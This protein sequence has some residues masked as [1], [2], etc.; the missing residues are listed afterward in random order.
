[1]RLYY[2]QFSFLIVCIMLLSMTLV[3]PLN[4]AAISSA[5]VFTATPGNGMVYLKWSMELGPTDAG[6]MILK[7]TE[8]YNTKAYESGQF[9]MLDFTVGQK[10][11]T[12]NDVENGTKYY[13]YLMLVNERLEVRE[14]TRIEAVATPTGS[15]MLRAAS[16]PPVITQPII[17]T[18]GKWPNVAATPTSAVTTE[19]AVV[20]FPTS[21]LILELDGQ[22]AGSV[23]SFKGG[24]PYAEVK[25]ITSGTIHD[26]QPSRVKYADIELVVDVNMSKA[27]LKWL[28][29]SFNDSGV[30]KNGSIIKIGS[31]GPM[32]EFEVYRLNFSNAF[33]SEVT[34]P[35]IRQYERGVI[36][37]VITPETT[38]RDTSRTNT[39]LQELRTMNDA[40]Y[41]NMMSWHTNRFDAT[42]IGIDSVDSSMIKYVSG[43]K[44]KRNYTENEQGN[45]ELGTVEV[46]NLM[47]KLKDSLAL[48]FYSWFNSSV[49]TGTAD[50]ITE[51]NAVIAYKA[52]K[53]RAY[54]PIT[55]SMEGVGILKVEQLPDGT[56]LGEH[57]HV[58]VD[59][60]VEDCIFTFD[61]NI[62]F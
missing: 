29:N 54:F 31:N 12:D 55:F 14:E 43:L 4:A 18:D 62:G 40:K 20:D 35:D 56:E 1:M 44:L 47:I 2:K 57:G 11:Y 13:Y 61:S 26:K 25:E 3:M 28:E 24:Y 37:L 42:F 15:N 50:A 10:W 52:E 48:P 45:K 21:Q 39:R 46:S 38:R 51:R 5:D 8:A 34:F 22:L 53:D 9:K 19:N 59:M 30:R 32:G 36:K 6:Y 27:F 23:V 16:T 49:I 17:V 41:S 60:Y 7:G 33:I 58:L